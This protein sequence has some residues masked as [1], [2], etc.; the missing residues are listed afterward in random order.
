MRRILSV[1]LPSWPTLR[2]RRQSAPAAPD[3]PLATV[4]TQHGQR[5]L[6]AVCPR[7]A[8]MGLRVDMALAEARAICPELTVV[9]ADPEADRAALA[10]LAAWCERYTPLA[11]PDPPDGLF[12]DIAGCAHLF[13][14]EAALAEDL[15]LRLQRN[16]LA[17]RIAVAGTA[18][19]AW[20]LAR[21]ATAGAPCTVLPAGA[22]RQA[23]AMLPVALLRL[24]ARMVAGL[25]RVGLKRIGELARQPR[26][27]L[28][29]R[30]GPLP[31]LRL[32]QAYGAAEA[33]IAWPRPPAPWAERLAFAE[34]IGTPEDLSRALAELARRLC[35]RLEAGQR[36]GHRFAASFLRVDGQRPAIAIATALPLHDAERIAKLLGEKLDTVAPGFGIDAMVL[37]AEETAPLRPPQAALADLGKPQDTEL[38]AAID[39]LANRLGSARLWR[40][41]P[42][43]S[44]VPER[45]VRRLPPLAARPAWE[46]D[47][48]VERPIR[49]LRRPEPIEATALVPDDPPI[50]FRWRGALHRVRAATGPERIAAE[51]WRRTPQEQRPETDLVRDYYRVEDNNGARFWIFR[52]GLEGMPRWF[53][54]G[55]FG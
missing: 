35:A 45:T 18:G 44:H 2:L 48:A 16:G 42:H 8:A 1:W 4:E 51:W 25:R 38:A 20:A 19:A 40:A 49:L 6:A 29:A 53:L 34:P 46:S 13:G 24:D 54:H 23:L 11:A 7:A 31:V 55:L 14:T 27:E 43:A 37:E 39:Q 28:S 36:G 3:K 15:S 10:A 47:P 30:F 41:A 12:L 32:D 5:R 17:H 9:E 22:E 21:S 50:L 26:A 33:A 52:A